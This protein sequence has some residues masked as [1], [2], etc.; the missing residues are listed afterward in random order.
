MHSHP[1]SSLRLWTR[2]RKQSRNALLGFESKRLKPDSIPRPD[3]VITKDDLGIT[4]TPGG[5]VAYS[6]TVQNVGD[7]D[8]TGV[9][10][11]ETVPA[12]TTFN[13]LASSI[14]WDPAGPLFPV[15]TLTVGASTT[16]TYAVTVD[17]PVAAGADRSSIPRVAVGNLA[18]GASTVVL[19][20][21]T[22]DSTLP[23]GV[24]QLSNGA[25]VADDGLNGLDPTPGNNISTDT[26]PVDAAPDL[27]ITKDDGGAT[28]IP[29]AVIVYTITVQNVGN[30]DATGVAVSETVPANT[31]FNAGV[32]K[33]RLGSSRYFVRDRLSGGRRQ[34]DDQLRG[35]GR[36]SVRLRHCA[37]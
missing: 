11:S 17:N 34:H 30:Q 23:V 29:G 18:A 35:H 19:Y 32:F 33:R 26:T 21:V 14:G 31:T 3:L 24:E 13:A 27:S 6:L 9:V 2:S 5:T 10:I 15:G 4:T 37:G 7:V 12:N 28:T 22:V 25:S 36:S 8:A 1:A 16:I 20:A